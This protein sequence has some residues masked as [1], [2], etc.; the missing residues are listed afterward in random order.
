VM[1]GGVTT[2]DAMMPFIVNQLPDYENDPVIVSAMREACRYNLHAM[3]NSSG[4]NG[5]G[6]DTIVKTTQP[7]VLSV[8]QILACAFAFFALVGG[9]LWFFGSR[10]LRKTEE[11]AAWKQFKQSRKG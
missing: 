11:Y 4:M 1:A 5:V 8:V 2:F 9:V 7:I 6:P 3:V 10:K